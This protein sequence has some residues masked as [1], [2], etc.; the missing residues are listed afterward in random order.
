[1]KHRKLSRAEK[2][3]LRAKVKH[4]DKRRLFNNVMVPNFTGV[5]PPQDPD[6]DGDNDYG[7]ADAPGQP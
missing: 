5:V 3:H 6:N 4:P 1:M 7:A 2:K